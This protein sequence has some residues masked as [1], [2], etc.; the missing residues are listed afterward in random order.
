[1]Q[2]DLQPNVNGRPPAVSAFAT[3]N[4]DLW[5]LAQGLCRSELVPAQFRGKPENMF[6]ALQMSD[7]MELDMFAV[8]SNLFV[9]H[10]TPAFSSKFLIGLA[11]MRGPFRGNL[12]FRFTGEGTAQL[13]ATCY[14]TL[15]ET[16]EEVS[17]TVTLAQATA[18]GWTKNGKYKEI[19]GQMLAYRA[20]AFFVRLYCPEV[21][22]MG[23]RTVD[24]V[25]DM[26]AAG[27]VAAVRDATPVRTDPLSVEIAA[28]SNGGGAAPAGAELMAGESGAP[29]PQHGDPVSSQLFDDEGVRDGS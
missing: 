10:G 13:A 5:R 29:V 25:E 21:A 8:M 26:Y 24:E 19:P 14:A 20:A 15:R 2:N 4:N 11:N 9:V 16:G 23:A 7:R 18:A 22:I 1:M 17:T 3:R 28:K 6:L 27:D 12:K